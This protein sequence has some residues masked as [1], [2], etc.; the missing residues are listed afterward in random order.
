MT[1]CA[2]WI[3]LELNWSPSQHKYFYM[4]AKIWSIGEWFLKVVVTEIKI[5]L[6]F[7]LLGCK[8]NKKQNV[9]R[10]KAHNNEPFKQGLV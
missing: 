7:Y 4:T 1:V 5:F 8:E 3:S 6:L 10:I 2:H 9:G